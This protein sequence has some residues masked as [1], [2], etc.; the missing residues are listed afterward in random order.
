[1]KV[2]K[3]IWILGLV[4][5][6]LPAV[7]ALLTTTQVS[8]NVQSVVA[9]TLTLPGQ[10]GV[11]ATGGGAATA[12]IEFNITNTTATN[13]DAQVVSGTVQSD[14]V[15]I[16]QFDNTGTININLSVF[17]NST[18]N[19]SATP[20]QIILK[21]NTTYAGA[22]PVNAGTTIANS[23]VNQSIVVVNAYTPAAAAQDYYLKADFSGT[24]Y[25]NDTAV[26][27]LRS[28]GIQS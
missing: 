15:P 27:T 26:R 11:S 23:S 2:N 13:V 22:N 25:T 1:M 10:S 19:I 9:Y 6:T 3:K 14:G 16:F 12:A 18:T 20:C 7:Y 24:C 17:M 8:F 21:G 28:Q 5:L 4:L